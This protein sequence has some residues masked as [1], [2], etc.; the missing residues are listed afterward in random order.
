MI[1]V[2]QECI[3]S[4]AICAINPTSGYMPKGIEMG[5]KNIPTF[6]HP[7]HYYLQQPKIQK[8]HVHQ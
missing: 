3:N 5:T 4:I 7:G 2:P 6:P 8:V 1:E